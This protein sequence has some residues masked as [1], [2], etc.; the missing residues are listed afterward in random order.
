MI[1]PNN[2]VSEGSSFDLISGLEIQ[3]SLIRSRQDMLLF[4]PLPPQ[5]P[6]PNEKVWRMPFQRLPLFDAA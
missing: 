5:E 4:V 6:Q 3:V 2:S 1:S